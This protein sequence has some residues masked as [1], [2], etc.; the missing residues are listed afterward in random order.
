MFL[1]LP[2]PETDP[3]ARGTVLSGLKC[4]KML[5]IPNTAFQH[6]EL[7]RNAEG[8]ETACWLGPGN[9]ESKLIKLIMHE[10]KAHACPPYYVQYN[11][12]LLRY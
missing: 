4:T 11:I 7:I 9:K 2:D 10:E 1:G 5:R 6:I 12:L 3:F 8:T